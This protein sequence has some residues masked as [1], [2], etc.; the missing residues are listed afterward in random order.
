MLIYGELT[1]AERALRASFPEGRWVDLR[2]G[3]P[4]DDD[5]ATGA[6]W[7]AERTVRAEVVAALLLGGNT[8][9]PSSV[10]S[11]RLAG[12]RITGR[13]DLAGA[14]IGHLLW[15]KE[16]RLDQPVSFNAAST[17]TIRITRSRVPGVDAGLARI[18]G[19]L[20]LTGSVMDTGRLSLINAYVAGE[21]T[22]DEAR[23]SAPEPWA[24]FAGGLVMG[25]GVFCRNGFT[26]RGGIR[27]P[28]AQLPGGLFMEGARLESPD[29][30]ALIADNVT[31]TVVHLSEG[32]SAT[33]TVR[34]RGAQ[35]SDLLTL[36]GATLGGGDTALSGVGMRVGTFDF[37]LA[38]QPAG[39][40]NLQGATAA[41]LH[42]GERSWPEEVRLDGFV[43]GS[44][45]SDR[46][47]PHRDVAH[48]LAWLRRNPGYA[49]QPYEQLASC[50]RQA[51]HDD[52]ARRVLLE[53]QRHRR[54]TLN[55]P[56]RV[57]GYLLDAAVGYGYR[58]WLAA[59]WMTALCL[60]GSLVFSAR[61][62]VQTKDGEGAPF[63]PLFYT[64]DLLFPIGDFGQRGAW[65]WTGATQWLSYVLIAIGWLL[66]TAVVAGVSRTLS[67]N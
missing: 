15:L 64:L 36:E 10:A 23:I 51:G 48:R 27:L 18:E 20:D 24:V 26:A 66:T 17:R 32:F 5:P 7:G 52:D 31:T 56:G 2:T 46:T 14:E 44:L 42:D 4:E 6:R 9:R 21:L 39:A 11:L 50:Y 1:A 37:T 22:L 33:G 34:L 58:P 38:A 12:A 61:S 47:P 55:A 67:R 62:P 25:G 45:R 65:H 53:K 16:C 59:L 3:E 28:G 13:L 30:E 41:V 8:E 63:N 60:L 43:Y 54:S 19:R 49:P 40:V 57:W 35:I 29:G